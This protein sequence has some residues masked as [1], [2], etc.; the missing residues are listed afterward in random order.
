M[1]RDGARTLYLQTGNYEQR[2]DLV[3]PRAL[4][5][6]VDAAH[7]RDVGGRYRSL[8]RFYD[9]FPPMACATDARVRGVR[10]TRTYNALTAPG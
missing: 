4:G 8:A 10:A 3:R 1:A 6:F 5:R 7:A 2:A 9:V